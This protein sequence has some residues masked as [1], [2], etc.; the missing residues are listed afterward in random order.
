MLIMLQST[1]PERIS[2][3]EGSCG[4]HMGGLAKEH[5]NGVCEKGAP[6]CLMAT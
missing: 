2:H 4:E 3:N 6:I 1:D 5:L